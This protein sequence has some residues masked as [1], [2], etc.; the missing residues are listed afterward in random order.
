MYEL[1]GNQL[2]FDAPYTNPGKCSEI[3]VEDKKYTRYAIKTHY[4]Q[5]GKD[6][7]VDIITRYVLPLY[8]SGDI[9]SISE[10]IISICQGR[11][12]Y[13]K[14]VKVSKL[15]IF[16]AKFVHI[17]PAGD[18]IGIPHKMQVAIDLAGTFRVIIAAFVSAIT[19]LFGIRGLFYS[20][21]GSNIASIDGFETDGFLDYLDMAILPPA[22]SDMVCNEIKEKTGVDCMIV[23]A[24]DLGV[25]ILGTSNKMPYTKK[26]LKNIIRDNPAGQED[27]STPIIL[28]RQ[29][30]I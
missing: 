29:F 16:L 2:Y 24:N 19:R 18:H 20:I 6:N 5:V 7:Y 12:V 4:I 30:M 10:K 22:N 8:K 25:E 9:I 11:V 15:A 13:K 27:Q 26:E 28:I 14:D 3:I 17:T 21:A 23:D 1:E